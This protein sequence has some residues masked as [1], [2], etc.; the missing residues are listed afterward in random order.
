MANRQQYCLMPKPLAPVH[1]GWDFH[2]I[3]AQILELLQL[4]SPFVF[5]EMCLMQCWSRP[6]LLQ[7]KERNQTNRINRTFRKHKMHTCRVVFGLFRS[8]STKRGTIPVLMTSSIGG[9]GSL[10]NSFRN[11]C[12]AASCS[13]TL[14]LFN[15]VSIR[16]K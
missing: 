6:K 16:S 11:F 12:V 7:T 15:F 9:F 4:E 2:T 10:D 3:I 14:S 5:V 8:N 1:H 13:S